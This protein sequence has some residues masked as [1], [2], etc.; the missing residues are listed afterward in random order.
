[1]LRYLPVAVIE[2][3]LSADR[4]ERNFRQKNFGPALLGCALGTGYTPPRGGLLT[5]MTYAERRYRYATGASSGV[6]LDRGD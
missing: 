1:M 2:D 5:R 6:V 4:P 3:A